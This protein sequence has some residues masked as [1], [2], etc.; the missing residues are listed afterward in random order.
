MTT[1]RTMTRRDLVALLSAA[2]AVG[3]ASAPAQADAALGDDGLYHQSW[4][5]NSFLD[6]REDLESAASEGKRLAIMW[7]LRGCP[8]CRETHL[9]NFAD[10]EITDYIRANFEVLQLNLL[11]ARKVIDF[12]G[13][14]LAEK[15][16]A[17]R[18][19]IR[20]TPTVQ[21]F[22]PS[23]E[24]V[25]AKEPLAREVARAPGYL[26]PPHFLAMFRFVRERAYERGTFRDYLASTKG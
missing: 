23:A 12:D 15:E 24:G 4:F 9:V 26:K 18:Y 3:P 22:P 5:L 17:E 7:E 10:Q 20:F 25:S 1:N 19:A 21:F 14:E 6:L 8:Y 2:A 11:G 16:L 13:N